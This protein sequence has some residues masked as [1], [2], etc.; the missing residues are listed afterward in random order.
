M[1]GKM[2]PEDFRT[3]WFVGLGILIVL[4]ALMIKTEWHILWD[5]LSGGL[6]DTKAQAIVKLVEGK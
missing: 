1:G 6:M 2:N 3:M 5:L 4:G